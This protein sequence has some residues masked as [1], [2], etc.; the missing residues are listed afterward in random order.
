MIFFGELKLEFFEFRFGNTLCFKML[1]E[2][3]VEG[4]GFL[5]GGSLRIFAFL[6]HLLQKIAPQRS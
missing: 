2:F 1:F 3:C 4:H 5:K 6:E